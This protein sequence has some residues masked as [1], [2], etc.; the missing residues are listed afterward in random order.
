MFSLFGFRLYCCGYFVLLI[1]VILII[2]LVS[3]W[4]FVLFQILLHALPFNN[5]HLL[6]VDQ[7]CGHIEILTKFSIGLQ[8]PWLRSISGSLHRIYPK[9]RVKSLS[10]ILAKL[11]TRM[12]ASSD[13]TKLCELLVINMFGSFSLINVVNIRK[14]LQLEK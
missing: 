5:F 13:F 12:L 6:M 9:T 4:W 14:T 2:S 3:F 1:L 11:P 7:S 8:K 10:M